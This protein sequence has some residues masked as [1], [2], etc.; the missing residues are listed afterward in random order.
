M[1]FDNLGNLKMYIQKEFLY[2]ISHK[3]MLHHNLYYPLNYII[4]EKAH[5]YIYQGILNKMLG[6]Y[7]V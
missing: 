3:T 5:F 4:F 1:E 2:S 6:V 7:I